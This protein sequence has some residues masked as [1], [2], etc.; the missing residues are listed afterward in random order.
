MTKDPLI[1]VIIPTYNRA[2]TLRRA[3]DSVLAQ[4]YQNIEIIVV[5]DGSTDKTRELLLEYK[6]IQVIEI[7]NHGVSFARNRGIEMARGFYIA[8]LDS[9]DEWLPDKIQD[10]IDYLAL[11][12]EFVW[13]HGDELWIR[14]GVRVN[15][16]KKHKKGG[17]D[18]FIPSL[19]LCV[20]A[21]SAVM[22]KREILLEEMFREDFPVCE[23]YDLWLRLTCK[24]PIA[25]VEKPLVK[26]HGGHVDQLSRSIVGMD[27]YRI[28]SLDSILERGVLND[29]R[30]VESRRILIKKLKVLHKGSVKHQN[31][32]ILRELEPYLLKYSY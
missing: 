23:D 22:I 17:G 2:S 30:A 18:Q 15:Q 24:Y 12:N 3:L 13:V 11:H 6:N 14:D 5:D 8:F 16:M 28:K 4:S 25:F 31:K 7:S 27:L 26:K 32:N 20:I 10:Q 1:S 19:N 9:D 29:L 21:P